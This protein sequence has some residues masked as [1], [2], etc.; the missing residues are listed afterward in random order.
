MLSKYRPLHTWN[1][2]EYGKIQPLSVK[3]QDL[4]CNKNYFKHLFLELLNIT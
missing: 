2:F 3:F 4:D 1:G